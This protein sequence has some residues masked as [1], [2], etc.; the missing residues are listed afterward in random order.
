MTCLLLDYSQFDEIN[1]AGVAFRVLI[2]VRLVGALYASVS[3]D[4]DEGPSSH[5]LHNLDLI[6]C[7]LQLLGAA[8][9]PALWPWLSDLGIRTCL[10]HQKLGLHTVACLSCQISY[11][12]H[13]A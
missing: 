1:A 9:F 10:H 6:M 12:V 8:P 2:F 4:C 11:F 3:A 13:A 5:S 7:S